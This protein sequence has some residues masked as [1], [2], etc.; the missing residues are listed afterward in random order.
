MEIINQFI[1][2]KTNSNEPIQGVQ[3]N[4]YAQGTYYGNDLT[5]HYV[6]GRLHGFKKR[7]C[8]VSNLYASLNEEIEYTRGIKHGVYR[9]WHN[10]PDILRNLGLSIDCIKNDPSLL[11]GIKPRLELFGTYK[12]GARHG[13]WVMYD[14]TGDILAKYHYK[15]GK[16]HG[17]CYTAAYNSTELFH[18]G[19]EVKSF[20]VERHAVKN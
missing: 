12:K 11:A 10:V 19:V 7:Y 18:N 3:I 8:R 4:G 15:K 13:M 17:L 5:E 6:D 2:E 14:I 9:A 1:T 20:N 16:K